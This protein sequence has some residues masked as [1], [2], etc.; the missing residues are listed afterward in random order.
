MV[1]EVSEYK[2][3][4]KKTRSWLIPLRA[5]QLASRFNSFLRPSIPG[6]NLLGFA[7][8]YLHFNIW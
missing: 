8:T 4:G 7:F 6:T 3:N 5:V 1:S 2:C